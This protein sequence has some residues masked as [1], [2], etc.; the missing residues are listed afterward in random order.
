VTAS[1]RGREKRRKQ[2]DLIIQPAWE[3]SNS[4]LDLYIG[5][6]MLTQL[7]CHIVY[8]NLISAAAFHE[9]YSAHYG[10]MDG[11]G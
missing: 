1:K 7:R 5:L 2:P 4:L 10:S 9:A 11:E 8:V 6:R 3:Q